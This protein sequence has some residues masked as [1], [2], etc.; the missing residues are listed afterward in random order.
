[1]FAWDASFHLFKSLLIVKWVFLCINRSRFIYTRFYSYIHISI[2]SFV[3][4]QGMIKSQHVSWI[5]LFSY[6]RCLF[7]HIR[8]LLTCQGSF[9]I[10]D[11]SLD[12]S[13]LFLYTESLFWHKW[14]IFVTGDL[15]GHSRSLSNHQVSFVVYQVFFFEYRSLLLYRNSARSVSKVSFCLFWRIW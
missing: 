12:I 9:H 6:E 3:E 7:W 10:Q 14:S 4:A 5:R 15:F 8:S 1:M 11:V 2:D 13:G